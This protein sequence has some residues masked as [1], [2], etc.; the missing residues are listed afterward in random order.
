MA[1]VEKSYYPM[2]EVEYIAEVANVKKMMNPDMKPQYGK[3]SFVKV[4]KGV[5][6]GF[7]L[8]TRD[9]GD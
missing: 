3:C 6:F 7:R 4:C 1:L 5:L 9:G 8:L 2:P